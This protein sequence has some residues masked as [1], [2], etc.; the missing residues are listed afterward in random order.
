MP[1][2]TSTF[3]QTETHSSK[4]DAIELLLEPENQ[5]ALRAIVEQLPKVASA[6]RLFGKAYDVIEEILTDGATLGA[7]EEMVRAKTGPVLSKT[8]G[9]MT[10]VKEAQVR[11]ESD[12]STIGVFG[13]MRLLKEPSVQ[14]NLRFVQNFLTILSEQ[15]NRKPETGV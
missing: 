11:A 3:D 7:I 12:S 14:K 1:E 8:S 10:A 15:N 4:A 5:E 13:L 6:M 9:V 2:M